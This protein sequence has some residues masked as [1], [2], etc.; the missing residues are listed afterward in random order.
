M[1]ISTMDA[2]SSCLNTTPLIGEHVRNIDSFS[3]FILFSIVMY[4]IHHG[5]SRSPGQAPDEH[6]PCTTDDWTYYCT[7]D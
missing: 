7:V 5:T 1:S 3:K 4:T 6:P 2:D